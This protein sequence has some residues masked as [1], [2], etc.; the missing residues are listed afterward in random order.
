MCGH[1][2]QHH[3]MSLDQVNL[4]LLGETG[5]AVFMYSF[6]YCLFNHIHNDHLIVPEHLMS[7][8]AVTKLDLH[9]QKPQALS[10]T[11]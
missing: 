11:H 6:I 7:G 3:L 1:F 9:L 4:G 10:S 5:W 8:L 2:H